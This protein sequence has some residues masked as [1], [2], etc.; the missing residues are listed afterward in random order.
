VAAR[1]DSAESPSADPCRPA[2]SPVLISGP[3]SIRPVQS[4]V[5]IGGGLL[6][7]RSSRTPAGARPAPASAAN[8]VVN[9]GAGKAARF[10][11]PR[12]RGIAAVISRPYAPGSLRAD[13]GRETDAHARVQPHQVGLPGVGTVPPSRPIR[14]SGMTRAGGYRASGSVRS[15]RGRETGASPSRPMGADRMTWVGGYRA[16]GSVRSDRGRETGAS[17]SRPMRAN[18]MTW[19]GGRRVPVEASGGAVAYRSRGISA[20]VRTKAQVKRFLSGL[21]R[22]A[23]RVPLLHRRHLDG[24]SAVEDAHVHTCGGVAVRR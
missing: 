15:D 3:P 14:A 23:P 17:P 9:R 12:G 24:A 11:F 18:R 8:R 20:D 22:P 2:Q 4:P 21:A 10:G 1:A 6:T 5:L 16:S 19:A 13:R 7:P